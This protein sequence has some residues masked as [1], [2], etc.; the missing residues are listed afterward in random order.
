MNGHAS[1]WTHKSDQQPEEIYFIL[2]TQG[3][4]LSRK[5]LA[6]IFYIK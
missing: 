3:I 4:D 5:K 2:A 6:A 1:S